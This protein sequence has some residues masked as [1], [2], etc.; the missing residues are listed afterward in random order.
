[1]NIN[2]LLDVIDEALEDGR[3]MPFTDN[4]RLVDVD[5][6]Q[7]A[8]D[9]IRQNLPEEIRQAKEIVNDRNNILGQARREAEAIVREA[10]ERAVALTSEQQITKAAQAKAV[11]ILSNAQNEARQ[12]RS[13]VIE[14]CDNKLK[15]LEENITHTTADIKTL[16]ANLRQ[17]NS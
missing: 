3:P 2:Q 8:L 14:C 1:M 11:E 13:G 16:R 9:S 6:V 17:K 12:M 15:A 7:D 10:R 5:V 4:R